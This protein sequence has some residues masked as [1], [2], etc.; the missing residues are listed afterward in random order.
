MKD[1][2]AIKGK[3][4]IRGLIDEGEHEHQD[5]KYAI[6]D[7]RKIA[8][9][10]SAFANNDGGRLLVGVKDNGSIV[11]IPNEED[12]YMI[13]HAAEAYCYPPQEVEMTAFIADGGAVVLRASIRRSDVRP[14]YC[15]ESG[16]R[17]VA[18]YRVKDE[19]FVAHPL[20][21]EAWE[22]AASD[23]GDA[24]TSLSEDDLSLLRH[25]EERGETTP[26]NYMVSCHRS[27]RTSRDTIVRLL[28]MGIVEM[29]HR[30]DG[31]HLRHATDDES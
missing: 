11:G 10:I 17:H 21:V 12:I 5:F 14:V 25:L 29:V 16:N 30:P 4:Y 3:F 9:S 31:F 28:A 27:E 15:I 19:N 13:E 2:K 23:K 20:M 24:M 26:E 22:L 8:R 1:I 18:Y 7:A 6:S